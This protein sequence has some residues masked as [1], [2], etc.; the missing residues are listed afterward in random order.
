[1]GKTSSCG[2]FVLIFQTTRGLTA[3][4]IEVFLVL[5]ET[6]FSVVI[7]Y[8]SVLWPGTNLLRRMIMVKVRIKTGTSFFYVMASFS[9]TVNKYEASDGE[10]TRTYAEKPNINSHLV[11]WKNQPSTTAGLGNCSNQS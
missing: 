5:R 4:G 3:E 6:V 11:I 10:R 1:M 8:L 7:V 2:T 9:N